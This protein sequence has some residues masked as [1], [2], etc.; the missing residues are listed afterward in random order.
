LRGQIVK[1]VGKRACTLE[2]DGDVQQLRDINEK[3]RAASVLVLT[4]AVVGFVACDAHTRVQGTI[5]DSDGNPIPGATVSLTLVA[6]GRAAKM[7]TQQDG[8]FSVELIHGPFSG[9]FGL[10]VSKSGYGDY[11]Q[12]I[13][14]KTSQMLRVA[15]TKTETQGPVSMVTPQSIVQQMFPNAQKKAENVDCFRSLTHE[16]SINMAVEKCGRPDEE[17]GSGLYIFVYHLRD[18]STVA[19][20]TPYLD[21]IF[22]IT[23]TKPSGKSVDLLPPKR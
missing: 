11:R 15:L 13:P 1:R 9:R 6:T 8:R 4:F 23:Y 3:L 22:D 18:G 7:S 12:E 10:I 19:I 14:S 17:V 16:T 5:V 20:G 21:R 2:Y